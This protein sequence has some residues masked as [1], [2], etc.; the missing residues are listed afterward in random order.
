MN[1]MLRKFSVC[2]PNLSRASRE[3]CVLFL[4]TPLLINTCAY[5]CEFVCIKWVYVYKIRIYICKKII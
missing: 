3:C 5:E 4:E 2:R 1:R